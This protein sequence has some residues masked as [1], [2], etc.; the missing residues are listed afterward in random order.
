[1]HENEPE[2]IPHVLLVDDEEDLVVLLARRLKK[3]GMDVATAT[4][5]QEALALAHHR[6][7]DVAVVDLKMPGMD[8][9]EVMQRLKELQPFVQ[10]IMF[11]GHGSTES[12]LEAGRLEA[13]RYVM[14]PCPFDELVGIIREALQHRQTRLREMFRAEM[15]DVM[16]SQATASDILA[17]GERLRRKYEQD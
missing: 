7:F 1:M 8:G 9:V 10:A 5:G 3:R 2:I 16:R 17:A 14:K 13:F 12:A 11:T 6:R 4:S 15:Q